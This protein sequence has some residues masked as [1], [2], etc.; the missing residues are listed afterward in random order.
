MLNLGI[1][2][3]GVIGNY[4]LKAALKLDNARIQAVCDLRGEVAEAS[5]AY[6]ISQGLKTLLRCLHICVICIIYVYFA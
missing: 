6:D 4:H 1:I 3:L 5:Y 2:G